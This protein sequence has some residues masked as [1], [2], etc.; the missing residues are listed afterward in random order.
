MKKRGSQIG[1][2]IKLKLKV[3]VLYHGTSKEIHMIQPVGFVA[4]DLVL[5]G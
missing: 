5:V 2:L 4:A 3:V 1:E